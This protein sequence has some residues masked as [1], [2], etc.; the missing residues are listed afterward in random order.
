MRRLLG[1]A[2][3]SLAILGLGAGGLL[4]LDVTP[5]DRDMGDVYRI[6]YV[7]VPAAWMAL[8]AVT[9]TFAASLAY[10]FRPSWRTDAL[11]EASA[12]IGVFFGLLL[13]VLGSIW[14]RPTWGVWWD[15][16]P[17]LTTTAIMLFA[18]AGYLALRRF[19]DDPE[20]RAAWSAIAAIVAYVDVPIL[21]FSVR[22]WRSLHQVQGTSASVHSIM[23]RSLL[24]N[25]GAFTLLFLW[26]LQLRYQ[27][28]R[29]RQS[30]DLAEPPEEPAPSQQG[31]SLA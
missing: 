25:A 14:A 24:F 10:L 20:R 4:G 27:V 3:P 31:G 21:W 28:A 30:V 2:L 8:L 16:D 17:R 6:M 12:E 23:T 1:L 26:F 11:A 15:W 19:V 22:W 29:L 9:I 13:L 5:A 18:F 7:H